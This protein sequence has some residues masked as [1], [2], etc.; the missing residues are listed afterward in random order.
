MERGDSYSFGRICKTM[1]VLCNYVAFLIYLRR[2][3]SGW[4]ASCGAG[5]KLSPKCSSRSS[6]KRIRLGNFSLLH[7][8]RKHIR[9]NCLL[10]RF[11]L[12]N[13]VC[14]PRHQ[15]SNHFRLPKT[16]NIDQTLFRQSNW[17]A[18]KTVEATENVLYF[19]LIF[20]SALHRISQYSLLCGPKSGFQALERCL[21]IRFKAAHRP[22]RKTRNAPSAFKTSLQLSVTRKIQQFPQDR[23][24]KN[25]S[26]GGSILGIIR[27]FI[28]NKCIRPNDA[29][30]YSIL[31][32]AFWEKTTN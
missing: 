9:S 24:C 16:F 19:S 23:S 17:A 13:L 8:L 2:I 15:Y 11:Q 1:A 26:G 12:R 6:I 18:I 4:A 25:P 5:F 14:R 32:I 30:T 29:D 31:T 22:D 27:C 20:A 7:Q 3:G 10:N 21:K 28:T